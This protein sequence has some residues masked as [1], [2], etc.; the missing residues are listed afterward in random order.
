MLIVILKNEFH[1][2]EKRSYQMNYK[3]HSSRAAIYTIE[4]GVFKWYFRDLID[5]DFRR[6]GD[7]FMNQ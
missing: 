5:F 7:Y 6:R 1:G 2:I 3:T 4:K